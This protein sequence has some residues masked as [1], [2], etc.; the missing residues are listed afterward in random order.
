MGSYVTDSREDCLWDNCT[1]LGGSPPM[2]I[3]WLQLLEWISVLA[4]LAAVGVVVYIGRNS[5]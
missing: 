3:D 2:A 5:R 1:H 4:A